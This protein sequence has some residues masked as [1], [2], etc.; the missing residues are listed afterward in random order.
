MTAQATKLGPGLLTLGAG[1]L[2][3][4]SCRL[5]AARVEWDKDKEDDTPVLCGDVIPGSTDYTAKLTGTLA[6]DLEDKDGVVNYS[7]AHKGEAV[8][9]VFVPSS[10]AGQQVTGT[11][12]VDP[13]DVGGDEVKKNMMSDF[14]WDCVG[15]PNLSD[16]AVPVA[17]GATAGTPG[18]W[19]PSGST[20][21]ADLT[22]LQA[23]S[24]VANPATAW[25]TGTYVVLGDLTHAHWTSSAWAAGDAS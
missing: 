22:A 19:T 25:A 14:E 5:S 2:M 24:V 1:G 18:S 20:P 23:S 4:I 12:V 8:P 17:A 21:P 9:F 7:W 3:D 10:T 13:L 11:V 16:Y 6:Q 15:E